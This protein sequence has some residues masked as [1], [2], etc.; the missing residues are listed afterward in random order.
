MLYKSTR[1]G[2]SGV[3]FEEVLFST[4][5]KD[6]GLYVPEYLPVLT[7]DMLLSWRNFTFPQVCAEIMHIFTGIDVAKMREMTSAAYCDFNDGNTPLP[8]TSLGNLIVLDASLGPTLSF[9]DIGQ[10]LV[11]QLLNY[12]LSL[13]NSKAKI[14]VE[15]S[16][17]TGP[18]AIAA[19][20]RCPNVE[21]F[22][23]YPKGRVSDLQERQMITHFE[24]N[25]H[26]YRTDGDTDEQASILKE[27]FQDTE[28]VQANNICSIN[29]IN[30]ARI[31]VQSTYYVWA[32]LQIYNTEHAIGKPV[33]FCVPTGAFGNS[34]AGFLAKRMGLPIDKII[35]ATNANDM[36]HRTIFYGDMHMRANVPTHSPAMDIQFAYNLERMLYYM[37]NENPHVL[38][39][40]MRGVEEQY[41]YSS[42]AK[43]VQL[44][45]LLLQRMHDV[46][47]SM[48]VSDEQTLRTIKE[49]YE[50]FEYLLCPH[51]AVAVYAAKTLRN[52]YSDVPIVCVQTANPCKF[53]AAIEAALQRK[54]LDIDARFT[55]VVKNLESAE[56]TFIDLVKSCDD[57]RSEWIIKLRRDILEV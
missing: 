27:I 54:A 31:A 10:Q 44:D 13:R 23:L 55:G 16:G 22:C 49:I 15:T 50:S 52:K 40:Y 34:M 24:K 42:T 7:S 19:V 57:W 53:E 20:C 14:V 21:I 48:S 8:L 25:V 11:G 39:E 46:F 41:K 12:Y 29:S 33:V 35:C 3:S 51:S 4:Y 32:Y 9:K 17:D 26:V 36:V 45:K 6:G 5:A 28:F 43:R 38:D 1:G 2:E 37:C 30:W 56:T 18:A 47:E